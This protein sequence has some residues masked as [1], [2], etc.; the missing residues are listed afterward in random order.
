MNPDQIPERPAVRKLRLFLESIGEKRGRAEGRA[1][2][3]AEGLAKGEAGGLANGTREALRTILSERGLSLSEGD[4]ERIEKCSDV[5]QLT[6]WLRRAVTAGTAS[7]VF[8]SSPKV[9]KPASRARRSRSK[10]A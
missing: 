1:E 6:V 4:R 7:E 8:A 5:E 10:S 2:G 9:R 3:L